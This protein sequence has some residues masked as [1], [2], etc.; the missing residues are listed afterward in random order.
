MSGDANIVYVSSDNRSG[1]TLLD[2]LLGG[3]P[4]ITSVGELHHLQSYALGDRLL[5]D[6]AH[7]L[8]CI[9]GSPVPECSFWLEVEARLG[10]R[11]VDLDQKPFYLKSHQH[12]G[13]SRL[14]RTGA[15]ALLE[16]FP[17]AYARSWFPLPR[18]DLSMARQVIGLFDAIL[19]VAAVEYVVDSSKNPFRFKALSHI[20]PHRV[21]LILLSRDF[22]DVVASKAKRGRPVRKAASEW[23]MR[24]K[25]M[26]SVSVGMNSD[27]VTRVRYEDLVENPENVL[28]SI[29]RFLGVEFD[30]KMLD[31]ADN[32]DR[33]HIGGSPSKFDIQRRSRVALDSRPGTRLSAEELQLAEQVARKAARRWDYSS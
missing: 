25:Q 1:S 18:I 22:R 5:Y 12:R 16:R 15:K 21:K 10:L 31:L 28:R 6:P 27:Q 19:E 3:H 8:I 2:L 29:S 9:C 11:L 14:I 7:P 20:A 24:M 4:R 23:A 32:V 30:A 13:V 26:E 33:H 17:A